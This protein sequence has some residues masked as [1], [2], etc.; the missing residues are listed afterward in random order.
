MSLVTERVS[1]NDMPILM[2]LKKRVFTYLVL[3]GMSLIFSCAP[4]GNGILSNPTLL[5]DIVSQSVQQAPFAYDVA[6]DTI[7]YN[8]C[9]SENINST[10][11]HGL[12]VGA[13]EGFDKVASGAS[14]SGLKL[15]TDFLQ[16]V[17]KNFKPNYPNTTIQPS[18]L[19]SILENSDYN[20]DAFIQLA[21]RQ[22]TDYVA[23]PDLINVGANN[24]QLYAQ[25]PRDLTVMPQILHSGILGYQI[26]KGVKFTSAGGILDEGPRVYNLSSDPQPISIEARFNLNATNDASAPKSTATPTTTENFGYADLYAQKVRDDFS[27]RKNLLTVTFGGDQ[28]ITEGIT[29]GD[30]QNHINLLKRPY[31]SNTQSVDNTK[32]FGRGFQLSFSS[33]NT[34]ISAWQKTRLTSVTEISLDNGQNAGGTSWT[35][36]NYLIMKAE[37]WDNNRMYNENWT[38]NDTMVE[39]SCVPIVGPD[40]TGTDGIIRQ[41]KI[42]RLRRHY[43]ISQWNIGLYLP[44]APRS[45]YSLPP[46]TTMPLCLTPKTGECYLPTSGILDNLSRRSLD[47]G[48]QYDTTQDCYLTIPG[49]GDS[50]RDLGRCANFASICI[51]NSSNF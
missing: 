37:H 45:G 18:Q 11:I 15:R 12:K 21:I 43:P 24:T 27:S 19:R 40:L 17:G 51:R 3:S 7:S 49:G 6:V 8:S 38:K 10:E 50:R 34:G 26:S 20:K 30:P 13:S 29:T 22:K 39:A 47:I 25:T 23:I 5:S 35:C 32:A 14:R 33:P 46:R 1:I 44:S 2:L 41:E 42:K 16:Y 4:Q 28:N 31:I 9:V 48:I 36:E